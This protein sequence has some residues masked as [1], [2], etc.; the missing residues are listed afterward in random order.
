MK[1]TVHNFFKLID[2]YHYEKSG[3]IYFI[4]FE[5]FECFKQQYEI[6]RWRIFESSAAISFSYVEKRY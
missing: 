4:S 3:E 6:L 1:V 5:M 2:G